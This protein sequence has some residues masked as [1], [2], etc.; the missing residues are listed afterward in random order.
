MTVQKDYLAG[1]PNRV[2]SCPN[3]RVMFVAD[4]IRRTIKKMGISQDELIQNLNTS[5]VGLKALALCI[6]PAAPGHN[7][8]EPLRH[9]SKDTGIWLPVLIAFWL[10]SGPIES[11]ENADTRVM[12]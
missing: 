8:F 6:E 7:D 9:I 11:D 1:I 5:T 12:T 4:R 10:E 3:S 2:A